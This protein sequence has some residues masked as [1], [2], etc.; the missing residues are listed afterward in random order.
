MPV[1]VPAACPAVMSKSKVFGVFVSSTSGCLCTSRHP[2]GSE[3]RPVDRIVEPATA[4]AAIFRPSVSNEVMFQAP[5][6]LFRSVGISNA[7]TGI[8]TGR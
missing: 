2:G 7:L 4:S 5:C 3:R 6:S 1:R 8:L